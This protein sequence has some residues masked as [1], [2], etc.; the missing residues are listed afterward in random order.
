MLR[1][2]GLSRQIHADAGVFSVGEMALSRLIPAVMEDVQE[3]GEDVAAKDEELRMVKV[4]ITDL[5]ARLAKFAKASADGDRENHETE[6]LV[7]G[8]RAELQRAKGELKRCETVDSDNKEVRGM[9][10]SL[11]EVIAT[12]E[13]SAER[14]KR[15]RKE[16]EDLLREAKVVAYERERELETVKE[17][18]DCER[19]EVMRLGAKTQVQERRGKELREKFEALQS[20]SESVM[21]EVARLGAL[22]DDLRAQLAH[23]EEALQTY[24]A[25]A[26]G[27]DAMYAESKVN[28]ERANALQV[29]SHGHVH[30]SFQLL[31]LQ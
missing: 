26:V 9:N 5:R 15:A 22:V 3:L 20:Q 23:K 11:R 13:K 7:L 8:L 4:E 19:E 14:E 6:R 25:Q 21:T 30:S 31:K 2:K 27:A 16:V 1:A 18:L 17:Q 24:R 10:S 29:T 28:R 12:M